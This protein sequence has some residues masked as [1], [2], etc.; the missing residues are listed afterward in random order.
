MNS[1][2]AFVRVRGTLPDSHGL[3]RVNYRRAANMKKYRMLKLGEVIR[4]G[5]EFYRCDK[6]WVRSG[7]YRCKVGSVGSAFKYR[8]PI[9]SERRHSPCAAKL[10]PLSGNGGARAVACRRSAHGR[11]ATRPCQN[12]SMVE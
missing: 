8:R 2:P 12:K 3:W 1:V 6:V 9:K 10:L 5:D 4:S 7:N 11:P